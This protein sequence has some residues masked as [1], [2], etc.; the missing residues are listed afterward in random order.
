ME[1]RLACP[2]CLGV[3]LSKVRLPIAPAAADAARE[4]VLDHCGRCGGVWFDAGEVQQLRRCD[5][6]AL[7][8]AVVQREGVHAMQCHACSAHVPRTVEACPACGW[9]VRL[10]CPHCQKQMEISTDAGLRLD[11]CRHDRGVWFDHDELADIWKIEA[12][13]LMERRA[14]AG[15]AGGVLD[16]LMYDPFAMYYG[17]HAAGYVVGGAAEMLSHAPEALAA[18]PEAMIEVAGAATEVAGSLFE[19]IV[20]IISSLFD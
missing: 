18:A 13:A 1:V 16:V 5:P 19:T 15:E 6:G 7:W 8:S 14:R 12:N 20:E 11:Y 4:L 2:V 10:D 3:K 9:K 17:I